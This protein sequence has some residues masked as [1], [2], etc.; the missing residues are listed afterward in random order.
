MPAKKSKNE[1]FSPSALRRQRERE[2]RYQTIL[3]AAEKLFAEEGYHKSSMEQLA[4]ASEVSVGAVYFYFKN[5]EDLIIQLM[6]EIGYLLRKTLGTV[7]LENGATM[8]S[9]KLAGHAF[10]E[11]FCINYPEKC[12]I[13]FR[14]SVGQSPLV[15]KHRKALFDKCTSDVLGALMAVCKNQGVTF[16]GKYSAEVIAVSIMGI[17]ERVAYQYLFWEDQSRDLK[18]IGRDAVAFLLGGVNNLLNE[19]SCT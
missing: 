10:F 2:H 15:E 13:V 5:K 11:D 1:N 9:F 8:E 18:T 6:D 4:N 12:A 16:K 19:T 7:F 14:E 17:Y 3:A